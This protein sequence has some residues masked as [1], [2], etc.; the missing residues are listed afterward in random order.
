MSKPTP[1]SEFLFLTPYRSL[2]RVGNPFA[3]S[4]SK[5]TLCSEP[6]AD[7]VMKS[8]LDVPKSQHLVISKFVSL[9]VLKSQHLVILE[10][11]SLDI[12]K[13]QHLSDSLF[14][15]LKEIGM[16]DCRPANTLIDPNQKLCDEKECNIVKRTQYQRM[17]GKLIYSSHTRLDIV[18][19]VSLVSQFM[20][21]PSER[22]LVV[23]QILRY[24]KSTPGKIY[25]FKRPHNK[26]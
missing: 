11:V 18:F 26:T 1:C 12:P 9:D 4:V 21:S 10:F 23:Y 7:S 16:S 17:V 13:S 5:P 22:Y 25:S 15:L 20:H 6:F 2:L 8:T 14:L 24:L 19:V 3:D